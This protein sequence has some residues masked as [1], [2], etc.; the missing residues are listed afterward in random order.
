[1][2]DLGLV[3]SAIPMRNIKDV[4][5]KWRIEIQNEPTTKGSASCGDIR[6]RRGVQLKL[7]WNSGALL[8]IWLTLGSEPP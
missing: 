2:A 8:P 3:Q 4:N 7:T 6:E 1:M 5:V